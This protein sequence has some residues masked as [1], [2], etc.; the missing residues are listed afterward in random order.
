MSIETAPADQ[1]GGSTPG[2]ILVAGA[3]GFIGSHLVRALAA[4]GD[5]VHA[6]VRPGTSL[7]RLEDLVDRIAVHRVD[8][9]DQEALHDCLRAVRPA[10]V[11]N[12][13]KSRPN[14]DRP[15]SAVYDNVMAAANLLVSAA[16]SGC[17]RFVQLGSS[18]EYEAR[19]GRLDE[20]TPLRPT[21][22]HG[23]TKAAASQIC[24]A[25]AAELGV[26]LVV[27]RPFQV[28]GPWDAP[29]HLVPAAIAAALDDRELVLAPR[30]RRDWI[31]ISDVIEACLLTLDAGLDG[32]DLNLGSG[33]QWR[34]E[35]VVETIGRL[36]GR[37][38]RVRLDEH[39]GRPWDRDDW[40]A[41]SSK[42]GALLGWKPR[43]DLASGLEA[44]IAWE[45]E[46]RSR[47]AA[48]LCAGEVQTAE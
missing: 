23:A 41:D 1:A 8:A 5:S 22:V 15:L 18:T 48:T 14:R 20:S 24:Q 27:L 21:S 45:H 30:G 25:L 29:S 33:R 6:L 13:V 46:R 40:R 10:A 38:I 43:H 7:A 19:P 11:V 12:A 35:E 4:R 9:C 34:N 47:P 37:R 17:A 44:T 2:A 28:Y 26:R 31:F 16:D 42:A 39:A 3:G 36:S 32:E